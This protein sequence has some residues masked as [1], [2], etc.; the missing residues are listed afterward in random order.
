VSLLP[1][2]LAIG[3]GFGVTIGTKVDPDQSFPLP[4]CL[5]CWQQQSL[6]PNE[7]DA[8]EIGHLA[9]FPIDDKPAEFQAE[10][11]HWPGGNIELDAA[12]EILGA[13]LRPIVSPYGFGLWAGNLQIESPALDAELVGE[14]LN[15]LRDLALH[16]RMTILIVTHEIGFA[17]DIG[18]RVVMFDE[19][20]VIEEGPPGEILV[21]PKEDRTQ[22]FLRAVIERA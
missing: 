8:Y 14:V 10:A 3:G 19:G 18:D 16:T 2:T 21:N 7:A 17:R 15:V 20:R 6:A 4:S 1:R 11:L 22:A 9:R 5:R 13:D 12:I